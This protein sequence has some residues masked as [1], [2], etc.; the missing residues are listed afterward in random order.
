MIAHQSEG[1][2]KLGKIDA[3]LV[4]QRIVA[5]LPRGEGDKNNPEEDAQSI[6]RMISGKLGEI[7]ALT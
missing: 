1:P 3:V 2:S 4:A 5:M 6:A 7:R